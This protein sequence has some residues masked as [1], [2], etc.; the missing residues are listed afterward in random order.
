MLI[1]KLQGDNEKRQGIYYEF[2]VHSK[3]IGIG[4]MG[5]V[6][7]GTRVSEETG[8]KTPVAIKAMYEDLPEHVIERAR[9]ESSIQ[10]KHENLIEMM[11]FVEKNDLN[12]NGS[13]VRHYH[14]I[15][16]Y[17][18]GVSLYDMLKG[19]TK[20]QFG[21][22]LEAAKKLYDEYTK[23]RLKISLKIIRQ[24]LSAIMSLHDNGYIHRDIDPSN[25]MI[26]SKGVVKL[27]DF[28]IAK[29][30][31]TLGSQ[32]KMLTSTGAFMGK[33]QYAAPEL[34]TGDIKHQDVTTDIYSVG[35]LFYQLLT[36]NLPF[37]GS[38]PEILNAQLH[39]KLS[40]RNINNKDCRLI[41]KKATE[42]KQSERFHTAAEFRVA[43]DN[44]GKSSKQYIKKC[45]ISIIIILF[46]IITIR[47]IVNIITNSTSSINLEIVKIYNIHKHDHQELMDIADLYYMNKKIP[48]DYEIMGENLINSRV[49]EDIIISNG[50]NGKDFNLKVAFVLYEEL[51]SIKG[52]GDTIYSECNKRK[53]EI[54]HRKEKVS[55]KT[56][57]NQEILSIYGIPEFD[58]DALKRL[59]NMYY[60]NRNVS[61]T[62]VRDG[63]NLLNSDLGRSTLSLSNNSTNYSNIKVAFILYV[64]LRDIAI[65]NNDKLLLE[66]TNKYL[67]EI[68]KT[69]TLSI[70]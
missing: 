34:I 70:N 8:K 67:D 27:I 6:Y 29:R 56:A 11:G 17:I 59:A 1:Q 5:K 61:D 2:D 10:V 32:D 45:F 68:K 13:N 42:K 52:L 36:G 12:T 28:G 49:G 24:V 23:D 48:H 9:R 16:E 60:T 19:Q 31:S 54:L 65:K 62:Y 64:Q 47:T 41:V 55:I 43:I 69:S 15:S 53:D 4:G 46:S 63:K 40:L 20:N 50:I 38:I 22:E 57:V 14:V 39:K 30:L 44:V 21:V 18:N 35:I 51:S 66:E 26:T 33:A 7:L 37:D 3:P 58:Y 25:I